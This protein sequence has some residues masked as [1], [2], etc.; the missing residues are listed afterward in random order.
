MAAGGSGLHWAVAGHSDLQWLGSYTKTDF[1][2][3][4]PHSRQVTQIRCQLEE[5]GV[6]VDWIYSID[7][8]QG[9]EK[10]LMLISLVR[11]NASG[12]LGFVAD[13][14][15]L[16]VAMT[17]AKHGLILFGDYATLTRKKSRWDLKSILQL[18]P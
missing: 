17:R 4:T 7:K 16:N 3:M 13:P 6:D 10:G 15:R 18:F 9:H 2:V 14:R 1:G 8:A 11:S 5:H 12:H